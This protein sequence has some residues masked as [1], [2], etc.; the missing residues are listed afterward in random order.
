MCKWIFWWWKNVT[1]S[2]FESERGSKPITS[3]SQY[4]SECYIHQLQYHVS[5]AKID[6]LLFKLLKKFM[7]CYFLPYFIWIFIQKCYFKQIFTFNSS[8]VSTILR[9][10]S[11]IKKSIFLSKSRISLKTS[12]LDTFCNTL[13]FD[14][15]QDKFQKFWKKKTFFTNFFIGLE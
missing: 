9:N 11:F 15:L 6:I 7:N 14:I 12:P 1:K 5:D 3:S 13:S 4:V 10:K 2:A 8:C